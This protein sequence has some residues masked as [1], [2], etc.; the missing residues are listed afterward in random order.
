M[1]NTWQ[2][3]PGEIRRGIH[4]GDLEAC[5]CKILFEKIPEVKV[6]IGKNGSTQ[7]KSEV[8]RH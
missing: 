2:D 4:S 6:V 7:T 3:I 5:I 8:P 1:K